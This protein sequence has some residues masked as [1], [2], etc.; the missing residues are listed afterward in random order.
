MNWEVNA[1]VRDLSPSSAHC[2]G[3]FGGRGLGQ[4]QA[5]ANELILW[6]KSKS[7]KGYWS[8]L[9]NSYGP[10]RLSR[11]IAEKGNSILRLRMIRD[12]SHFLFSFAPPLLFARAPG[13]VPK[14]G[15]VCSENLSIH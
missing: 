3:A 12:P 5:S 13:F 1:L 6:L 2:R 7:R 4:A 15:A 11:R 14:T 9:V 10:H 8:N